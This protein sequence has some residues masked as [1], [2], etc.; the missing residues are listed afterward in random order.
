MISYLGTSY[1]II[2]FHIWGP[3]IAKFYNEVQANPE[4]ITIGKDKWR[5]QTNAYLDE[6]RFYSS[7]LS[8]DEVA[9]LQNYALTGSANWVSLGCMHCSRKYAEYACNKAKNHI[10]TSIRFWCSMRH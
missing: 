9:A 1:S 5:G 4:D 6:L 7:A 10:C 3:A 8:V 2:S